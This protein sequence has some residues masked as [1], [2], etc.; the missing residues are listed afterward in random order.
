[1]LYNEVRVTLQFFDKLFFFAISK[2]LYVYEVY[3]LLFFV[4]YLYLIGKF[5]SEFESLQ[6]FY[7]LCF[8]F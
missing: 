7:L 5:L 2:Y 1:M 3:M 4:Y 8:L 6:M